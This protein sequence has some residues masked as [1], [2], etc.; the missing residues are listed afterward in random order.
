MLVRLQSAVA[1]FTCG[2]L[3][4]VAASPSN[5]GFIVTN[6]DAQVDGLAVHGN[7][8]LF[9]GSLVQAGSA[10]SDLVFPGGST[11]LLQ[12]DSA[13]R[14]YRD[15]AVLQ[16]GAAVQRGTRG[17]LADGLRI[18]SL[19]P[20]NSIVVDL[21]D[22]SHVEVLAQG[23]PAEI[24]STAGALVA[25]LEPGKALTLSIQDGQQA[26]AGPGQPQTP[27]TPVFGIGSQ[28]TQITV[29]GILRKDHAG[30]YGHYLLTDIATKTTLEL[31]GPGLDDLVGASVEATG[32]IY[33]T[34]PAEG[35]S[36]VLSVADIRQMPL[37]EIPGATAEPASPTVASGQPTPSGDTAPTTEAG[38]EVPAPPGATPAQ[39]ASSAPEEATPA[40]PPLVVHSDTAKIVVIV[41]IA[42]GAAVGVALGLGGGKSSTV[43][44]E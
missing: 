42:A 24:R 44:P 18:S 11:L 15:Y 10:T 23:G 43:S 35:A 29:R 4:S 13:A 19:S 1:L 36:K 39:P 27:P 22:R 31:Q 30:R 25:R 34:K 9:P 37:N 12:P 28:A 2:C 41:A 14:V 16:N 26:P 33:D 17:L 21:K 38:A 3:I 7:S 6:G 5:V 20:Q 40:P 32:T 8:T